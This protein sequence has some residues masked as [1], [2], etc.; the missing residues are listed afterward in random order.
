MSRRHVAPILAAIAGSSLAFA[1]E[2]S[3]MDGDRDGIVSTAEHAAGAKRMFDKMDANRDGNVTA[4]E[5]DAAHAAIAKHPE[6]AKA[7]HDK[8]HRELSSAEK[9]QVIDTNGDGVL[10]AQEHE[11]GSRS[12][13]GKMDADRDGRLTMA[14]MHAGH[15]KMLKKKM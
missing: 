10:S 11:T 3:K 8:G 7:G 13:F 2:L 9:I 1:D 5:M 15:D 6:G 12:M 4:A 14:E